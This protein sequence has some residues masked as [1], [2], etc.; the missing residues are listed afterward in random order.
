MLWCVLQDD[1]LKELDEL[2]QEELDEKLLDVGPAATDRLPSV[3]TSEPVARKT[4]GWCTVRCLHLCKVSLGVN[5]WLV[6]CQ[7]LTVVIDPKSL[8]MNTIVVE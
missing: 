4:T 1:L 3:P 2:E 8:G 6:H 7:V 5:S